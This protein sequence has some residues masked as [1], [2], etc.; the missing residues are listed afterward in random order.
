MARLNALCASSSPSALSSLVLC[1]QLLLDCTAVIFRPVSFLIPFYLASVN[2]NDN[3]N[4]SPGQ[5][6]R[7]SLVRCLR[8]PEAA[9]KQRAQASSSSTILCELH[10][11]I[12]MEPECFR[13]QTCGPKSNIVPTITLMNIYLEIAFWV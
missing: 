10:L 7:T 1:N 12:V 2:N 9:A 4:G 6:R 3:N 13:P 8:Q 5:E 11:G